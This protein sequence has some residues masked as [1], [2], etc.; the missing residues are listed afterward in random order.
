M[1]PLT[2]GSCTAL[3][4]NGAHLGR[5]CH[6]R[7]VESGSGTAV[8]VAELLA[9]LS[10]AT[11]LGTGQP[12][13][14]A[15]RTCVRSVEVARTL[16]LDEEDVRRVHQVALLR[17]L[18]CSSDASETAGMTGGD[19]LAFVSAM[20]P[21]VMGS[22]REQLGRFVRAV[23]AG[24]PPARRARRV[25]AA[26]ADPGAGARSLG[27][28]CEVAA[29][30]ARRLGLDEG[31]VG[32]LAH[33]YER[34][35]GKGHPDGLAG[36]EVRV[37]VR[38]VSV[39]RDA[40]LFARLAPDEAAAI[41]QGR[42]GQAYN[43]AVVDA[44]LAGTGRHVRPGGPGERRGAPG[45]WE[46]AVAA[47]PAP[48]RLA[49]PGDIDRVLEAIADFADLYSPWARGR[50]P[51]VAA[52]AR[53]AAPATGLGASEAHAIWRAALVEDVGRVGVPAGVWDHPGRLGVD[54]WEQVRLHPYLSERVIAHGTGLTHLV[55]L[56][57]A[58]HER[59][60][61]TGY[62]RGMAAGAIATPARL[63]AA[64]DVFVAL[65]ADGPHRPAFDPEAVVATMRQEVRDGRL[66]P[67]SADAVLAAAGHH[68]GPARRAWPKG[69]TDREVDVLRLIA[70]GRTNRGVAAELHLSPKTVGRHIENLYGK[71]GVSSRAA[72]A[73]F[74]MEERLLEPS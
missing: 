25:T 40:E 10:L 26:L 2:S 17:F 31:T 1:Y 55:R 34:W 71:I 20:A 28:H 68:R 12:M 52:L 7:A 67:A 62:H 11:D 5:R 30:L 41:L 23:G 48:T 46:A 13:G 65:G 51:R 22:Q 47:E 54:G 42:R 8:P 21:V 9:A 74:A 53:D 63:L 37:A 43:P 33:A 24:L 44:V 18:G 19:N 16:G 72:A 4:A 59:L 35:D 6:A 57:G 32:S 3:T 70:R 61:G 73:L 45:A 36:V 49:A 64:A 29:H 27:A 66:D 50:S 58:H 60:D 56:A 69:L 39:A 15:L 14:H 38:I